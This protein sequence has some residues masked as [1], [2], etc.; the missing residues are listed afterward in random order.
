MIRDTEQENYT[1]IDELY[2]SE[3]CLQNNNASIA[4]SLSTSFSKKSSLADFGAGIGTL[5]LLIE[6]IIGKKPVCIEP[7]STLQHVLKKRGLTTYASLQSTTDLFDGIYT[8]N[9]LEHIEDDTETLK[10]LRFAL[11]DNGILAIY[12]P[13]FMCLYSE[14]DRKVGHYRRYAKSELIEKLKVS[15]YTIIQCHYCESVGF[16]A[17]L[18]IKWFGYKKGSALGNQ[19]SLKIYDN[20]IHPLNKILDNMGCKYLFGKNLLVIARKQ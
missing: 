15:G 10:Q 5:A 2:D 9:V 3:S 19:R 4:N 13:A 11:K 7:D 14:M 1:G 6:K 18:A 20:Y 16:F 8:S 12:V 17:S